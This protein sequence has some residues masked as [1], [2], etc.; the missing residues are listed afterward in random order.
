MFLAD[1]YFIFLP[2]KCLSVYSIT[3]NVFTLNPFTFFL[4]KRVTKKSMTNDKQH[5]C[6]Y[7]MIGFLYY[8]FPSFNNVVGCVLLLPYKHLVVTQPHCTSFPRMRESL[9]YFFLDKKVNKKSRTDDKQHIR[10]R[11]LMWLLYYCSPGFSYV[12]SCVLCLPYKR[13]SVH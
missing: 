12:Y 13:L 8:C 5:I 9:L 4:T 11:P 2:Y 7:A 6:P 1:G 10:S 3:L